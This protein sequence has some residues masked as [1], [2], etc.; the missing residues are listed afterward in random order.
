MCGK[1]LSQYG[2]DDLEGGSPPRVR[3]EVGVLA[4]GM[5]GSRI[6]PACAGRSRPAR[7]SSRGWPDHPRVCGEKDFVIYETPPVLGSPPRV[8]GEVTPSRV[9]N[10]CIRIT[11]ACAGRSFW[12]ASFRGLGVGSPPR[13]RGEEH[14]HALQ[15]R[16]PGITP[17]CAG[18][19]ERITSRSTASRDH[20]R[21]RGEKQHTGVFSGLYGGSPLR[22]RGEGKS[23]VGR[24]GRSRITPACAGRSSL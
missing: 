23:H 6:T 2:C 19:R 1:K 22:A 8:R 20:P 18:R 17:A 7:R 13:V 9:R 4:V 3:G 24:G 10:R 16:P 12:A 11:P 14:F 21:V 15:P 5:I